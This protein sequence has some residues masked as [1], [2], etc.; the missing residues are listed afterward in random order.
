M[1]DK[2]HRNE[3][4]SKIMNGMDIVTETPNVESVSAI[5]PKF[6]IKVSLFL[7]PAPI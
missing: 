4:L 5:M 6:V 7:V 3:H 2:F 1:I